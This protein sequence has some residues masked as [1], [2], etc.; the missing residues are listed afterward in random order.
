[1]AVR[2]RRRT[3]VGITRSFLKRK[4]IYLRVFI[5]DDF[6]CRICGKKEGQTLNAHHLIPFSHLEETR[7]DMFNLVSVCENPCH[8]QEAH[9][10]DFHNINLSAKLLF[11]NLQKKRTIKNRKFYISYFRRFG[12]VFQDLLDLL[13]KGR[14]RK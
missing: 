8:I 12:P 9:L 10:G 4:K 5:R 2:K 7:E 1:M 11:E 3:K 6:T 13:E 14:R